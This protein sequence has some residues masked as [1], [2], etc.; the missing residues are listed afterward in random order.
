M[1]SLVVELFVFEYLN[2]SVLQYCSD[3]IVARMR[4]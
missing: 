3:R 2:F 1:L 4:E